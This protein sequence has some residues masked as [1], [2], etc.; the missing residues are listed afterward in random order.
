MQLGQSPLAFKARQ[1]G[2]ANSSC[3]FLSSPVSTGARQT[4]S[5]SLTS[6]LNFRCI[7]HISILALSIILPRAGR[8]LISRRLGAGRPHHGLPSNTSHP[9]HQPRQFSIPYAA[10]GVFFSHSPSKPNAARSR[11][12]TSSQTRGRRDV[13]ALFP[14]I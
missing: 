12:A 1:P 9:P 14:R 13:E 2:S 3:A 5:I 4:L 10:P 6:T 7:S 8:R 11:A